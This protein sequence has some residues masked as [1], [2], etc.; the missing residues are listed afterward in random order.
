MPA[1]GVGRHGKSK[2]AGRSSAKDTS[3]SKRGRQRSHSGSRGP[4]KEQLYS[5]AK[6]RNIHGRSKMN[7]KQLAN[8]LG[9]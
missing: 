9:H 3:S 5:E 4:P 6:Q 8:T 1:A 2:T 7:K